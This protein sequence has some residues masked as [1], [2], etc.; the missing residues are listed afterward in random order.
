MLPN[1]KATN[2]QLKGAG[3]FERS[4]QTQ[5]GCISNGSEIPEVRRAQL[6]EPGRYLARNLPPMHELKDIFND[7]A[8]NAIKQGLAAVLNH[9]AGR[10]LRVATMCSG[11]ESP[12]LALEMI[13]NGLASLPGAGQLRVKHLFSCEIVPFKQAYIERNFHPPILFRDIRE[14]GNAEAETAYGSLG[15]IPGNPDLLV[16][17]TACVD[18]SNLNSQQKS[19]EDGGE[20]GSTF[21]GMLDYAQKYRPALVIQENVRS[22]P[23][24]EIAH[25]WQSIDYFATWAAI[26]TKAYYIP[27]TRERGYMVCIDKARLRKIGV[28]NDTEDDAIRYLH[29][30]ARWKELLSKFTRPASSPAGMFLLGEDDRRLERIEK[31]MSTRLNATAV[32]AEVAWERYKVR[33]QRHRNE[34]DVGNQRPITRSQ[35][36]SFVCHPP[37]FYW[38]TYINSQA[39]RVWDT[40]DINF[41]RKIVTWDYD[42]NFKERWIELSQGVDRGGESKGFGIIGCL[43]PSG[44]PFLTTRGAPLTG[45]EALA[46]QGLPL[47]RISLT[48]ES[49]RELQDLAGNAMSSTCVG[50]AILAALLVGYNVLERGNDSKDY[51]DNVVKASFIPQDGYDTTQTSLEDAQVHT[52]D[53]VDLQARATR[54]ARYCT[55]EKQSTIR[56]SIVKCGLCNHTACSSCSGNPSHS[57]EPLPLSRS[58]PSG[59]ITYLKDLL[60]MRLKLTGLSNMAFE[61]FAN[62]KPECVK[63]AEWQNFTEIIKT[64]LGEELRFFDITRGGVWKVLYKGRHATSSLSLII[65]STGLQWLYFA[66]PPASAPS[67]SLIREMLDQPIARMTPQHKS[68]T[69]GDWEIY[70]PFSTKFT[71]KFAGSGSQV[72]TFQAE[73]G[74]QTNRYLNSK[75]WS[76]LTIGGEEEDARHW[77]VDI[78]GEYE[79]LPDCGTALGSLHKKAA[80]GDCPAIYLFLDPTKHGNPDG[81]RCVFSLEHDRIPGYNSRITIAELEPSWRAWNMTSTVANANAFSRRWAKV[82]DARLEKFVSGP[83]I[84]KSLKP[85]VQVSIGS[86]D[87]HESYTTLVTLSVPAATSKHEEQDTNWRA[88]DSAD[89][90]ATL[91]NFVWLVQKI[92]GWREFQDW[93][94]IIGWDNLP[95]MEETACSSCHPPKPSILWGRDQK[96]VIVPYENPKEAGAY[97]RA[98]K[99]KPSPFLVFRQGERDSESEF[100]FTLNVQTLAHQAYGKLVGTGPND[101]VS[102]HWR[103]IPDA[104]DLAKL[105]TSDFTLK[106]NQDDTPCSQP[107]HFREKLRKEQLQS[108]AWMI[109][110]EEDGVTPFLEEETEEAVLSLMPWR[111][112]VRAAIPRIVRGG[113]LADEVGYGKTAIILGLIDAQFQKD[114]SLSL[115]V[116]GLIPTHATLIVVPDNVFEQW[117][118]EIKK[119]LGKQHTV[120]TIQGVGK[121]RKLSI[122]DIQRGDII[123][124]AWKVFSSNVYYETLQQFTGTPEPPAKAGRNF[125]NWFQ[126]ARD[127]LKELCGTLTSDGPEEY[128]REVQTRRARVEESQAGYTYMPSRR[129]RGKGFTRAQQETE[130]SAG[131][132]QTPDDKPMDSGNCLEKACKGEVTERFSEKSQKKG[133]K[134]KRDQVPD[135]NTI[136]RVRDDREIFNIPT[137]GKDHDWREMRYPFLHL[138][139]FNRIVIDEYTYICEERLSSILSLHSRSKWILSGTPAMREFADIKSIARFLDIYL[140][141]D[142][143]GDVPTQNSRLKSI[144]KSYTAAEAFQTYQPRRS[145]AWYCNRRQIAQRF[146]DQFARQN[147]AEIDHIATEIHLVPINQSPMEQQ[148]YQ[149]LFNA[150][151]KQNGRH[152]K[153]RNPNNDRVISRLN[154]ILSSSK[155]PLEALIKCCASTKLQNNPWDVEAYKSRLKTQRQTKT[156]N[157]G[158]LEGLVKQAA[159]TTRRWELQSSAWNN[160]LQGIH[161]DNIGDLDT[162]T[163]VY[164]LIN[165]CFASYADWAGSEDGKGVTTEMEERLAKASKKAKKPSAKANTKEKAGSPKGNGSL[166]GGRSSKRAKLTSSGLT[167][168]SKSQPHSQNVGAVMKTLAVNIISTLKLIVQIERDIR[169]S[170]AIVNLQTAG[171]AISCC[172]CN[173]QQNSIT[174]VGLLTSCGHLLCE[175]CIDKIPEKERQCL[176]PGCD[177]SAKQSKIVHGSSVEGGKSSSERDSKIEKLVEILQQVPDNE[178]VLVFVQFEDL[179]PVVS[180]ALKATGIE[181]RMARAGN[182]GPINE[183]IK[184]NGGKSTGKQHARPKVLI[185]RLGSSMAAGLNLQCANHVVFLSPL[186]VSTQQEWNAGMTQAIG[187]ARR[188]GQTRT[189][190]VYHLLMKMTVDVNVMQ[191]REGK[192]LVERRG[193]LEWVSPAESEAEGV[194]RC[195]GEPFD[196]RL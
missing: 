9:L 191:E 192:I 13:Q 53:H 37:D 14:L 75:T 165:C 175:D 129:V 5:L 90:A 82:S 122:Q 139:S 153:I 193:A 74:L 188:Y 61:K 67:Q 21:K 35:P 58:E 18:F 36:G 84:C 144:R 65:S 2:K 19:L 163:A 145:D 194:V 41:L 71:L 186:L 29:L 100:R 133:T 4:K 108:L 76:R 40:L 195:G 79:Y 106:S 123:V 93:N 181:H 17:G 31:D 102:L 149:T 185:L 8:E 12:L 135:S 127:A 80:T 168:G 111:A 104:F 128:L 45:L 134:R 143:D 158:K 62:Y 30:G 184:L 94:Q 44:M 166:P 140:G 115:E 60:P 99:S 150:L 66:N 38:H 83:I 146:L 159:L 20:S 183:F 167:A 46:L 190:H 142:D 151:L 101:G 95:R 112:E 138:F 68:L 78:R 87:C 176:V 50:V 132:D 72:K 63:G 156:K 178:L 136:P 15:K 33:H 39:E 137:T 59:F 148:T 117:Q 96:N 160:W 70:S 51:H 157:Y 113:V 187:R 10:P 91:K 161:V 77:D 73:C 180:R 98:V 64:V 130:A 182:M 172:K 118:S 54:S 141:V 11:T 119:F 179:M 152:R 169:F 28:Q 116:S 23:W 81:D 126:D 43:T 32:R 3:Q 92:S 125:D 170:E 196:V 7:L 27:Q 42:M 47:D 52:V 114:R 121:L 103:L 110:Q 109:S 164:E 48:R 1:S 155:A 26:D 173:T 174:K 24:A 85:G 147:I 154:E 97:E 89:S 177:G 49:Q 56:K 25:K 171:M 105:K 55:C 34:H 189:V 6:L 16:A 57:Y 69:E 124:V 88:L 120:L 162:T 131:G 107:P 86:K 22:A